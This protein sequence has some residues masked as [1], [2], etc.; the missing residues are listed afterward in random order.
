MPAVS[1]GDPILHIAL[2]DT[3]KQFRSLEKSVDRM[4][5]DALENQVRDHLATSITVVEHI[6][7]VEDEEIIALES[8]ES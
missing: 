4:E 1:P 3:R 7:K 2:S 5:D 8:E 6:L